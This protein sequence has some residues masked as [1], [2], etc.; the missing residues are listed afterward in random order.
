MLQNVQATD[1]LA[2]LTYETSYQPPRCSTRTSTV[3]SA[4]RP[5]ASAQATAPET[6]T[7]PTLHGASAE[8]T[9]VPHLLVPHKKALRAS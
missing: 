9:T 3:T 1:P 2:N 5:I 8:T 7:S 6:A 4:S